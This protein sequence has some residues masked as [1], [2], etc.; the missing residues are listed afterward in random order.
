MRFSIYKNEACSI[1][2]CAI[3][4]NGKYQAM[5]LQID[6]KQN[7]EKHFSPLIQNPLIKLL[8]YFALHLYSV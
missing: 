5:F 3:D 1:W 6:N 8:H 2:I 7:E 4:F